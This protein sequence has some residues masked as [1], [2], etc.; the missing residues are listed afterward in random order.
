[1]TVRELIP[2]LAPIE[3][4]GNLD[5]EVTGIAYD[6]RKVRP[7]ELFVALR[8]Q[9]TDGHN[10]LEVAIER[11]ATAVIIERNGIPTRRAAKIKVEDSRKA[12]ARAAAQFYGNP[13][14]RLKLIGVTGTN[15][16]TTVTFL[17]KK[18]LEESGTRT[19]LIGT[20][21]YVIGERQIPAA[22]T[23]P[24]ALEL[25]SMMAQMLRAG[26]GACAM[27]VSSHALD[28]HRVHGID[29]DV[30]VFTNLTQD[31]L[32][33]HGDMDRYFA[34][35]T[36]L[37]HSLGAGSKQGCAVINLDDERGKALFDDA[38]VRA[39]KITYGIVEAADVRATNVRMSSSGTEFTVDSPVGRTSVRTPLIGRHN[40][41]NSLA[42][43]AV[44]FGL[45]IDLKRAASALGKF[46][47]VPGRLDKVA[48]TGA[49]HVFIDY[50][51]TDDALLNVLT[52][53]RELAQ[54]K[55][56]VV[57]GCGGNRDAGKRPKMG[58]V[59]ERLADFIVLTSDNPRKEDPREIL[60]QIE[61]GFS[62]PAKYEVVV[63]RREAIGRALARAKRNDIVLIAGK[64]H[65]AYQEFSDTI[66][67]FDDKV[68]VQE[69]LAAGTKSGGN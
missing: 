68:V 20:V 29:F 6:S 44:A 62:D 53:L 69:L 10:F 2:S 27:E 4:E 58:R 67:P 50:A 46:D 15:G 19:G 63:D 18:I 66:V 51:H 8:G 9:H 28:Q 3:A 43:L 65:E 24:E 48:G 13:A 42:A 35:K 64:G 55:L 7:G 56:I 49:F 12:L 11:G 36:T 59:A 30:A 37:F 52:T 38:R 61:A 26:C 31:H 57:F 41:Y 33:Y 22:R 54:G 21:A 45:G 39:K 34:A 32:D 16:K 14:S 25:Q 17:L 1:M 40:I 47:R 60:R 5:R 23:T